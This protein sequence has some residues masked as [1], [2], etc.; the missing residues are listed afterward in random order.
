[1]VYSEFMKLITIIFSLLVGQVWTSTQLVCQVRFYQLNL[2]IDGESSQ[3]EMN[4]L[5]DHTNVAFGFVDTLS[6]TETHQRL[7]FKANQGGEVV[8][9]FRPEDLYGSL[10]MIIA[11]IDMNT[12]SQFFYESMRCIRQ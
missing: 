8:V 5:F 10:P 6:S 3:I 12:P 1:M 7:S 2:V 9:S 11:L 4:N